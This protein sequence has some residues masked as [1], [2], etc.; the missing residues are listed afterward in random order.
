MSEIKQQKPQQPAL[1]EVSMKCKNPKC[2]S[3][4]AVEVPYP[5]PGT[6]LYRCVK[7]NH[8]WPVTV[9]GQMNLNQL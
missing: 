6:N 9:G 8:T 7:C 3:I 2:A 1:K 5:A 4:T